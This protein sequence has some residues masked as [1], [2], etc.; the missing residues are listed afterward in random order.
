[1]A[2]F[3]IQPLQWLQASI[4]FGSDLLALAFSS[5]DDAHM[6]CCVGFG[7]GALFRSSRGPRAAAVAG[8][9]GA[10]AAAGLVAARQTVSHNL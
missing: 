6:C 9:V 5:H 3:Q 7:T 1:M 4:A 8:A 2:Q 10:F